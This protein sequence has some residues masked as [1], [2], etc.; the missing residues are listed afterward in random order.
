[1]RQTSSPGST[2]LSLPLPSNDSSHSMGPRNPLATYHSSL[3]DP[4][5]VTLEATKRIEM[6]SPRPLVPFKPMHQD[7]AYHRALQPVTPASMRYHHLLASPRPLL[8]I[9]LRRAQ[10]SK[11]TRASACSSLSGLACRRARIQPPIRILMS[12]LA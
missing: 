7:K 5:Q 9:R 11:P 2:I 4:F 3:A 1:M 8:R 6:P 10:A 12:W